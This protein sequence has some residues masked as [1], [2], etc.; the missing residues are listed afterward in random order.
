MILRETPNLKYILFEPENI[1]ERKFLD[2]FPGLLQEG[3]SFFSPNNQLIVQNLYTRIKAQKK[4]IKYTPYV[5]KVLTAKFPLLELPETFSYFTQPLPPQ[6]LAL[7]FGYTNNSIG[8][9]MEPGLGKTKVVLDYI[10]LRGFLKALVICPKPLL[11]VWE[12]ERVKHRPEL[13]LYTIK[14]TDWEREQ[15]GVEK[16]QVIVL[17]YDKA[18]ILKEQLEILS[19]DFIGLDEGLIKNYKTE[20][21]QVITKLARNIPTRWVMSG[22]LIN[23][24]PLDLFAPIRF[25]EPSLV[26]FGVTKFKER[27]VQVSHYNKN[28]ITGFQGEPE[29]KSILDAC[30]IVMRKSEWLPYLPKKTFTTIK[31]QLSSQQEKWYTWLANN[32][33]IPTSE[34]GLE[35]DIEVDLALVM[36]TKLIQISNGF[37]YYQ[38]SPEEEDILEEG[39]SKKKK[40]KISDR[41]V[42][43]FPEQPKIQKLLEI[44]EDP[45]GLQGRRSIVWFNLHAE[46]ELLEKAFTEEGIT[47]I[48]IAGGEKDIGG[49]VKRFNEDSSIRFCVCQAKTINYGVT[50]IGVE[51]EEDVPYEFSPTIS[52]EIFYS[53]NFSLE[54]YLQQQDRI[55]RIGQ[56]EECKYWILLGNTSVEGRI[57]DRLQAKLKCNREFLEDI[58]KQA[59][60]I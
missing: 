42:H 9:L 17:N 51:A 10:F 3:L 28:I 44:M 41:R 14:T 56:K 37:I 45:S 47:F 50:L 21:T 4:E 8:L 60:I 23:N 46:R 11:S 36:L 22:T 49:K 2:K 16:N 57:L 29:M 19:F 5:K 18:V 53:I 27:Y 30:S 35:K 38:D 26:G 32:W 48:T 13:T 7:R 12:D 33:I 55:H 34:T 43:Y 31:V 25:I 6:D 1:K 52:D 15:E 59:R 39:T 58:S 54:V 20:R 24:S 40:L